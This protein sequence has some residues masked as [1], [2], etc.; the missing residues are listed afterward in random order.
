MASQVTAT[1]SFV[2]SVK[3]GK[4]HFVHEG[5]V[6]PLTHPAVKAR[7]ELFSPPSGKRS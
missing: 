6:L 1:T 3:G 7:R 5:E 4:E 2:V